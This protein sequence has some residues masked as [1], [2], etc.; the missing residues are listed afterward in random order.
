M[1][2]RSE[3][4]DSMS[5]KIRNAGII[6]AFLVVLIH[7]RPHFEPSTVGWWV[8]EVLENGITHIAVPFFFAVTGYMMARDLAAKGYRGLLV[9]R[10][11]TLGLPFFLWNILFWMVCV[12]G[13]NVK[14]LLHGGKYSIPLMSAQ[15][16]GLWYT[17][18][19]L[20]SPL[21]YVRAIFVLALISPLILW[22]I[23]KIGVPFLVVLFVIYGIL[24]PFWPVSEGGVLQEFFR[25]GIFPVLGIFYVALGM[26]LHEGVVSRKT[27]PIKP[28]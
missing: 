8:K 17:G 28:L 13:S 20:L 4:T 27:F 3:L 6:C 21:W 23:R 22:S 2:G 9:K 7:C 11:L 12:L 1:N 19:P 5:Y 14:V 10:T 26:A 18:C 25:V 16:F 15:Q 24:C